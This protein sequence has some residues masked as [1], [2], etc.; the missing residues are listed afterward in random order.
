MQY[1]DLDLER[2]QE[3]LVN[4]RATMLACM[5][6]KRLTSQDFIR[7]LWQQAYSQVDSMSEIEIELAIQKIEKER[8]NFSQSG[9]PAFIK[10]KR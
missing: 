5:V 4:L 9:T 7:D 3:L 8:K 2:K 6:V 10:M 1:T